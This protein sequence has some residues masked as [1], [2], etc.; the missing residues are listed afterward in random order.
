MKEEN[1]DSWKTPPAPQEGGRGAVLPALSALRFLEQRPP[2]HRMQTDASWAI[3][4]RS[5]TVLY[6]P[7]IIL[8][9]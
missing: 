5:P 4:V 1:K 8:K 3:I 7:C 6:L 9:M 2:E